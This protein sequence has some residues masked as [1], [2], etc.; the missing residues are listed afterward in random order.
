MSGT[1]VSARSLCPKCS[2]LLWAEAQ[3]SGHP[4]QYCGRVTA[5]LRYAM[6]DT[7]AEVVR[8]RAV[9]AKLLEA[10]KQLLHIAI[11]G[12]HFDDDPE[13]QPAI[14]TGEEE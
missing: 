7:A 1:T 14:A 12:I 2:S 8:V 10:C 4:C 5:F 9:N 6:E 3:M 11:D 13:A